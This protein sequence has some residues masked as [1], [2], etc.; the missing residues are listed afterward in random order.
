MIH[1]PRDI[2]INMNM[3]DEATM[4]ATF[5][6]SADAIYR[7]GGDP[8]YAIVASHYRVATI[9]VIKDRIQRQVCLNDATILAIIGLVATECENRVS[10]STP[11]QKQEMLLHVEGLR[12]MIAARGG[13][14]PRLYSPTVYW[15]LHW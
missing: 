11:E 14:S 13:L 3:C 4:L 12:A 1:P 6:Y 7:R 10:Q 5:S 2:C 15:L 9:R 8:K